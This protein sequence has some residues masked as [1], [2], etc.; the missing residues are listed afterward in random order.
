MTE[1]T[2][3]PLAIRLLRD[4]L[5]ADQGRACADSLLAILGVGPE[6]VR[7][8]ITILDS[9]LGI[10]S[11]GMQ[12]L[13][14]LVRKAE[15][16]VSTSRPTVERQHIVSEGVLR[17]FVGPVPSIG[18]RLAHFDL[19]AGQTTLDQAKDVGFVENF[20]PVDSQATE[21]LWQTVETRLRQ[22]IK[23]V[24]NGTALGSPVH[25]STLRN[26]VA[27]HYTRNP[28]T[29]TTH[30]QSFADALKRGVD[31][32][33][34]TPHAARAFQQ[35]HGLVAAGPEA[36]RRG[37]EAVYGRL[38]KLHEEG[39]L[40]RLSVQRLF[41]KVCDRFE[42]RGIQILTPGSRDKEFLLGDR[43]AI[44]IDRTTGATGVPVDDADEIVMPMTP[45]LLIV[46][47]ESNGTCSISDDEVDSYNALQ[48]RLAHDYLIHRPAATFT[49]A[50]IA[51]W[52]TR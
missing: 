24:R 44:T 47:G 5:A 16:A 19:A 32:L 7:Q 20:V 29:L 23:A 17:C 48:A 36:Q 15:E 12:G 4:V 14:A 10:F 39:G 25:A 33:A 41:E 21:N 6:Y 42:T 34:K 2:D 38:I 31:G 11:P 49:A 3:L 1:I 45:R 37:A 9:A 13:D 51:N 8:N 52:R 50:T 46:L 27:L 18:K 40:F 35:T 22:A 30:N 43:P 26:A 28:Q